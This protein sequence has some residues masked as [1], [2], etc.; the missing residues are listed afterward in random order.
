MKSLCELGPACKAIS[1]ACMP[2]DDA[3]SNAK[4]HACH[5]TGMTK[6]VES[7]C[8]AQEQDCVSYCNSYVP[9]FDAAGFMMEPCD[10]G[11]SQ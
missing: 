9:P 3:V 8:E 11:S 2:K 7:D 1:M 5:E 6:A 10:G 4:V